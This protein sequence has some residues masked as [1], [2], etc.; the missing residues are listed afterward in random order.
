MENIFEHEYPCTSFHE[1]DLS[2]LIDKVKDIEILEGY[3]LP[4]VIGKVKYFYISSTSGSDTNDGL[5]RDTAVKTVE[6]LMNILKTTECACPALF[7]SGNGTSETV[8]YHIPEEFAVWWQGCPHIRGWN[9][10]VE[11]FFD[12]AVGAGPRFYSCHANIK[13]TADYPMIISSAANGLYF[14]GCNFVLDNLKFN[15]PVR[16]SGCSAR[17]HNCE[18]ASG[19]TGIVPPWGTETDTSALEVSESVITLYNCIFKTNGSCYG[20]TLSDKS[21]AFLYG[22]MNGIGYGQ[23]LNIKPLLYVTHSSVDLA[24]DDV[25]WSTASESYARFAYFRF[26]NITSISSRY[27]TLSGYGIQLNKSNVFIDSVFIE[28]NMYTAGDTYTGNGAVG[29]YGMAQTTNYLA[30]Y[31]HLDKKVSDGTVINV[32]SLKGHIAGIHGTVGESSANF[33]WVGSSIVDEIT[34][35]YDK[36]SGYLKLLIK[37]TDAFNGAVAST[38]ITFR[39]GSTSLSLSFS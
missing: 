19:S 28:S 39:G 24:I 37:G 7:F 31:F 34:T 16:V 35:S 11:L 17:I 23:A 38:P 12:Y 13:S 14:E 21:S 32:T 22:Y 30:I 26:S 15:I 8:T 10:S 6:R 33:E 25:N 4:T 3:N 1:L 18:F 2:W 5:T 29:L 36:E 27:T 20:L 9:G